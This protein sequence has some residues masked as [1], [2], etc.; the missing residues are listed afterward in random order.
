MPLSKHAIISPTCYLNILGAVESETAPTEEKYIHSSLPFL[1][2]SAFSTHSIHGLS[3]LICF[4]PFNVLRWNT[5]LAPPNLLN[6][7]LRLL[8]ARDFVYN[9][10]VYSEEQQNIQ[11]KKTF[12]ILYVLQ[13][14]L[15]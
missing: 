3:Y 6:T 1:G 7:C 15:L 5:I 4:L 8:D 9:Q 11:A 2:D 10:G 13:C 12:Y 14:G